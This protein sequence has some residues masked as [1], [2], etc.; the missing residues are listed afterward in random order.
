MLLELVGCGSIRVKSK[1][2]DEL[3][4]EVI[5]F[6]GDSLGTVVVGLACVRY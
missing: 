2:V 1:E 4:R 3:L 6:Y 5:D